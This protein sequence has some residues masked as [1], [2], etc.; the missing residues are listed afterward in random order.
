MRAL[1]KKDRLTF[2]VQFQTRDSANQQLFGFRDSG[3]GSGMSAP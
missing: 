1:S 2:N 3:T